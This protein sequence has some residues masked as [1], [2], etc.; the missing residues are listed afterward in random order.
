LGSESVLA[1]SAVAV[2]TVSTAATAISSTART[3]VTPGVQ[4]DGGYAESMIAKTSG[5]M[6]VPDD[7]SSVDAAHCCVAGLTTFSALRNSP[8]RAGDLVAILGV[9]GL[10]HL[11]VQYARRM[12]FEVVG[13]DRG[14]GD[15][16]ELAKKLGAHHYVDSSVSDIGS[17]SRLLGGATVVLAT[18]SGGKAVA[19]AVNGLRRAGS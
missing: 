6:S 3:R 7:L 8:A 17:H 12:G 9:G 14:A 13:I 18:A 16:A 10:G 1:S 5:L 2:G 11:G 15:R 19:A 4:Q